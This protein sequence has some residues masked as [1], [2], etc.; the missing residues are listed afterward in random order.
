MPNFDSHVT[1]TYDY[2]TH[3]QL[4]I[5][6]ITQLNKTNLLKLWIRIQQYSATDFQVR[7]KTTLKIITAY[8][9][10]F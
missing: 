9:S 5:K 4:L 1:F 7:S 3:F 6:L 10:I 8:F 2:R